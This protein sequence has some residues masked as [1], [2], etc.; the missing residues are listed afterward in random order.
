[1]LTVTFLTTAAS[2]AALLETEVGRL[3]LLDRWERVS[4]A[5]G[6]SVDDAQY[7]ALG[8]AAEQGTLYAVVSAFVGGPLLT[9]ALSALLFALLRAPQSTLVE[10]PNVLAVVAHAGVILALRQVIITPIAYG[11]ETLASPATALL[12]FAGPDPAS[13]VSRLLGALDLFVVWWIVVLAIGLGALY[14]RPTRQLAGV[15]IG[16]YLTVALVIAIALAGRTT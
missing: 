15:F 16:A 11:R 7:A 10:F 3:A 1:M 13:L 2:S 5:F 12:F 14:H 6:Q 4:W 9:L 8:Q